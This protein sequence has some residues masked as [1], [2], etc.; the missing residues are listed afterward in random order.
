MYIHMYS[1]YV[2]YSSPQPIQ[3]PWLFNRDYLCTLY[4]CEIRKGG[5]QIAI[6]KQKSRCLEIYTI[7]I[8]RDLINLC[9]SF[10]STTLNVEWSVVEE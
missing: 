4:F 7:Y 2:M 6:M 8:E 3:P 5:L 1:M 9:A 10:E